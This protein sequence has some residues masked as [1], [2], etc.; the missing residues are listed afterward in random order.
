MLARK[1]R[2]GKVKEEA[3]VD[4]YPGREDEVDRALKF[5]QVYLGLYFF[6]PPS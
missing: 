6:F 4:G 1:E 3:E 2:K 5:T